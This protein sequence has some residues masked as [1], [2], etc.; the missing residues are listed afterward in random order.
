MAE[1]GQTVVRVLAV[2]RR[3]IP[4]TEH[5]GV[6]DKLVN[7]VID[8][9]GVFEV[10]TAL[11]KEFDVTFGDNDL[12]MQNFENSVALAALMDRLRAA[13]GAL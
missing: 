11:E 12:T 6:T 3:V 8:S 10:V 1:Q 9:I 4:G 7:S 2:I 5:V 13:R